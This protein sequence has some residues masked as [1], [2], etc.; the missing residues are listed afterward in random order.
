MTDIALSR[1]RLRLKYNI[2]SLGLDLADLT[3]NDLLT[4]A[5]IQW[6]KLIHS[7]KWKVYIYNFDILW[8]LCSA[9][10]LTHIIFV[11]YLA[12]LHLKI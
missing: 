1:I 2:Y 7:T 5:P 11:N 9:F 10:Y 4:I 3:D 8:W 6:L 12:E